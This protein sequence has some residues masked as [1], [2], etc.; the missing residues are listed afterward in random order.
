MSVYVKMNDAKSSNG[1]LKVWQDGALVIDSS[2]IKY[3]TSNQLGA[4]SLMFSTFFGGAGLAYASAIDT[5]AYFK[6]I[7]MSVG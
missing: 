3:R 4:N 5:S 6:D 1:E 2:N 7:E